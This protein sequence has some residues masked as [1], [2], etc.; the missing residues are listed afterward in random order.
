MK[1]IKFYLFSLI[2]LAAVSAPPIIA[3][4]HVVI[5][6]AYYAQVNSQ[7]KLNLGVFFRSPVTVIMALVD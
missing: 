3:A 2:L 6:G 1:H 7:A 5:A 4:G